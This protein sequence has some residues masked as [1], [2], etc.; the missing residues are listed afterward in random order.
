VAGIALGITEGIAGRVSPHLLAKG[1]SALDVSR[2]VAGAA[3]LRLLRPS[4]GLS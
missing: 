1:Q 3:F 2:R 4:V